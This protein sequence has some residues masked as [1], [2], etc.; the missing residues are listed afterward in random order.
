VRDGAFVLNG[1]TGAAEHHLAQIHEISAPPVFSKDGTLLFLTGD[2]GLL[3]T[4]DTAQFK[5]RGPYLD[6]GGKVLGTPALNSGNLYVVTSTGRCIVVDTENNKV[7][8][9]LNLN[10][11]LAL[12]P[13]YLRDRVLAISHQTSSSVLYV[14]GLLSIDPS[15]PPVVEGVAISGAQGRVCAEPAY[16]PGTLYLPSVS[17]RIVALGVAGTRVEELWSA[18]PA[19][20]PLTRVAVAE[21]E[22]RIYSVDAEG[23]LHA[24]DSIRGELLWSTSAPVP[25]VSPPAAVSGGVLVCGSDAAIYLI[26]Y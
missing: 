12:G 21:M 18:A 16:V 2:D 7:L 6:L 13:I 24:L 3:Y 8:Q 5:P 23:R 1:S 4:Y 26:E 15:R 20:V 17:G 9:N 10:A 11:P 14:A 19:Q 22:N 25:F